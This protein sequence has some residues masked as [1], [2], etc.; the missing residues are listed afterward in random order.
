LNREASGAT[1]G[2]QGP[3]SIEG[4]EFQT[5][6]NENCVRERKKKKQIRI[7]K[8]RGEKVPKRE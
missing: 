5:T 1:I 2:A 8:R 4:L 6:A 7:E 3:Q